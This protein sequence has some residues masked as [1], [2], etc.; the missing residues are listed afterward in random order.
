MIKNK[1][2]KAWKKKYKVVAK[3]EYEN[4]KFQVLAVY[5]WYDIINNVFRYYQVVKDRKKIG[6]Y[7]DIKKAIK[8]MIKEAEYDLLDLFENENEK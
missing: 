5:D 3:C 4:K 2:K 6:N 8:T 7:N 1:W